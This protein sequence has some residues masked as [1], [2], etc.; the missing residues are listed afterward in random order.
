ME[1]KQSTEEKAEKVLKQLQKMRGDV[2]DIPP[3]K[4]L[5]MVNGEGC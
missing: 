3:M 1:K 5:P 4:R 2:K